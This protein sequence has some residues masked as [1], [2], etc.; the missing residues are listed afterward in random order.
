MDLWPTQTVCG[1]RAP[2]VWAEKASPAT[3]TA[4]TSTPARTLLADLLIFMAFPPDNGDMNYDVLPA[5]AARGRQAELVSGAGTSHRRRRSAMWAACTVDRTMDSGRYSVLPIHSRSRA[6]CPACASK[7][8][9]ARR[10]GARSSSS[11]ALAA[12]YR[13]ITQ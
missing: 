2:A 11:P 6:G 12:W 4:A 1:L 13:P 7:K 3:T 9:A 10:S 5:E 8:P